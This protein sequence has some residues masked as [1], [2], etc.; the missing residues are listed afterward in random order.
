MWAAAGRHKMQ[1]RAAGTDARLSLAGPQ[2]FDASDF[3]LT[4][5]SPGTGNTSGRIT[6][7]EYT[8]HFAVLGIASI[9]PRECKTEAC[10][11]TPVDVESGGS[12]LLFVRETTEDVHELVEGRGA[13]KRVERAASAMPRAARMNAPQ[14]RVLVQSRQKHAARPA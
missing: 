11:P 8:L 4:F 7:V 5:T 14:Q 13:S 10:T 2:C 12:L 9:R 1:M 3:N 6:G